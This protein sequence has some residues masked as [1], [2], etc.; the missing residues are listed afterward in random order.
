MIS[1]KYLKTQKK[2]GFCQNSAKNKSFTYF[3][4]LKF[5]FELDFGVKNALN[6]VYDCENVDFWVKNDLF[7]PHENRFE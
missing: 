6:P 2:N 7:N 4:G 3:L 5:Y 1:R